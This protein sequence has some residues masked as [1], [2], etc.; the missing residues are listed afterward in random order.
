MMMIGMFNERL[1]TEVN[2]THDAKNWKRNQKKLK[3]ENRW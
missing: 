3:T 1:K 2:L